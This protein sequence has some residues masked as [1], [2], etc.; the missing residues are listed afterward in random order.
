M[1][2]PGLFQRPKSPAS[3]SHKIQTPRFMVS[4]ADGAGS[5]SP[6]SGGAKSRGS[7]PSDGENFE[8]YG[9]GADVDLE[10]TNGEV[11]QRSPN[12]PI[13]RHSWTRTSLRRTPPSHQENL[14]NRRWGSMRHSGKRQLGS[15]AL[16]SQ[17][18]RSSSFNSSGCGSTGD[19][20]EDM[21]SDVSLEED[22]QGLN[23]KVQLLQQQVTSLADTQSTTDDR[24]TRAKSENAVLQARVLFLEEQV[25]DLEIKCED[26]ILDEQRRNRE[27]IIRIE[28][29]RDSQI[30][31][32]SM[33]LSAAEA[34]AGNHKQEIGRLRGI[35]EGLRLGAE[36]EAQRLRDAQDT[37]ASL[38][39]QL[40]HTKDLCRKEKDS[41]ESA[42]DI[43]CE[44]Q[45]EL[46]S[47][48]RE[49]AVHERRDGDNV[50]GNG[51]DEPVSPHLLRLEEL[52]QDLTRLRQENKE[53]LEAH[54]ELQ[55]QMLNKGLETG[56]SLLGPPLQ[57]SLAAELTEMSN[58]Q[59]Q[60]AL[61]E[62]QEINGQLRCYI[63]GILLS[64]VE[65]YPHLL[66]VKHKS[67]S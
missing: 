64:I 15:N 10:T 46:E 48:R 31:N 28:R 22:V 42:T 33:R 66:E 60:K 56:R 50:D 38:T 29:D 14:P 45:R 54:E 11:G 26:R 39:E 35:S 53:L 23:Y 7:S 21:Y 65:N 59:I 8:C 32:L 16:A 55:A 12:G 49:L 19:P 34:E 43:V 61:K 17:L 13:N 62:Q 9:E 18:Y 40:Q 41:H 24:Y 3:V 36:A 67:S 2:A 47:L 27:T 51:W 57:S 5:S 20:G 30:E 25:R 52:H 37:I 4:G 63:D 1:M 58:D 6:G 44:L